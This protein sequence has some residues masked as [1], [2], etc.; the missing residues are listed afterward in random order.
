MTLNNMSINKY[1]IKNNGV[2]K[3]LSKEENAKYQ[4]RYFQTSF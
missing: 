3:G 1:N 2:P 4:K